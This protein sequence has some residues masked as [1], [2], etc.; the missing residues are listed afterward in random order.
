MKNLEL[1]SMKLSRS[2]SNIKITRAA[3][4]NRI[5]FTSLRKQMNAMHQKYNNLISFLHCFS[6]LY[7]VKSGLPSYSIYKLLYSARNFAWRCYMLYRVQNYTEPIMFYL[8]NSLI[9]YRKPLKASL[10][11]WVRELYVSC[12]RGTCGTCGLSNWN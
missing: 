4:L 8:N 6:F 1:P 5:S 11:T 7:F 2:F 10:C 9:K 12:T 3:A